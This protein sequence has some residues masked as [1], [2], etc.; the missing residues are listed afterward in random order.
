[1]IIET[2]PFTFELSLK[3]DSEYS[4]FTHTEIV[5]E[6]DLLD[7]S[8]ERAGFFSLDIKVKYKNKEYIFY[9][10]GLILSTDEEEREEEL[11]EHFDQEGPLYVSIMEKIVQ[12]SD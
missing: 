4:P 7:I 12:Y 11:L 5:D 8:N 2:D 1:M 9:R 6:D 3:R 10:S